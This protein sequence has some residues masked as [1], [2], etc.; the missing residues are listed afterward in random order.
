MLLLVLKAMLL[1]RE[2]NYWLAEVSNFTRE[3]RLQK[4]KNFK[5]LKERSTREKNTGTDNLTVKVI[6]K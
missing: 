5:M 4:Q 2:T 1:E 6:Q 3:K